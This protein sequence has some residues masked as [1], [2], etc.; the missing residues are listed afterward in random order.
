MLLDPPWITDHVEAVVEP[1]VPCRGWSDHWTRKA[2]RG[3]VGASGVP[4]QMQER[5]AEAAVRSQRVRRASL[6]GGNRRPLVYHWMRNTREKSLQFYE[7]T[8]DIEKDVCANRGTWK[9]RRL[10]QSILYKTAVLY[11]RSSPAEGLDGGIQLK[12]REIHFAVIL[13]QPLWVAL[14]HL[15]SYQVQGL[16]ETS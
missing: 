10:Y 3:V 14:K 6:D 11:A 8:V 15:L 7:G 16:E 13:Y 2:E 5:F 9:L 12:L 1:V 4:V